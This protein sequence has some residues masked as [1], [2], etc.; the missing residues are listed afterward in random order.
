VR[1]TLFILITL[2]LST[3]AAQT[4]NADPISVGSLIASQNGGFTSIDLATN[5]G[6][7]LVSSFPI[8]QFSQDTI[9]VFRLLV[10]G[11]A[12]AGGTTLTVTATQLGVTQT[13]MHTFMGD[14][15]TN[16]VFSFEFPDAPFIQP[17]NVFPP[18]S[19][20]T[21]V[22][23]LGNNTPQTY[24][25]HVAEAVPEPATLGLLLS[26]LAGVGIKARK[27]FRHQT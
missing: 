18:E 10:E 27:R 19:L 14:V 26:G 2:V 22:V 16:L 8:G 25:A 6:A 23:T 5:P 17:G 9:V 21:F 24:T 3:V 12:D 15:G 13:F 7:N 1:R 4:A 11:T 20:V